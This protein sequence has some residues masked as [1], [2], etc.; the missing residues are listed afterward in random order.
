MTQ[1]QQ[2]I[3][4]LE[5]NPE[6]D[7]LCIVGSQCLGEQKEYSD[8]D[9]FVIF[10]ENT[11]KLFSLFQYIDNK[12]ADIFFYEISTLEKLLNDSEIPANTMDAVLVNWLETARIEFDKSET[13][14]NLQKNIAKVKEKMKVPEVELK[15]FEVWINTAYITNKRYFDSNNPE[16]H[17]LLEIKLLQDTYNLL[18]AYFEYRNIPWRGEKQVIRY[19]KKNDRTFYNLYMACIKVPSISEKFKIYSDLVKIV[20]NNG[21]YGLWDKDIINPS[22]KGVLSDEENNNIVEYWKNLIG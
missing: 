1:L 3:K 17:E 5:S 7:A 2:I 16:Y 12:P 13:L 11:K 20:F 21:E 9:L 8:I 14:P 4:N 22:I 18:M 15:K 6:I 19:L 10:K